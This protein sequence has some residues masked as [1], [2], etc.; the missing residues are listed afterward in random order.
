M[1]YPYFLVSTASTSS[2]IRKTPLS[3]L[4]LKS[5]SCMLLEWRLEQN[6]TQNRSHL[7]DAR[8][9]FDLLLSDHTVSVT[10][11]KAEDDLEKCLTEVVQ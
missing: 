11:I 6:T 9:L 8:D 10:V 3:N 7:D 1:L 4:D 5:G 2:S